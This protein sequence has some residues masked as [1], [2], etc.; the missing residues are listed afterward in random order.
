MSL[1]KYEQIILDV[2]MKTAALFLNVTIFLIK[3]ITFGTKINNGVD[4]SSCD[5]C[6]SEPVI[7][8]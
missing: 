4:T 6:V 7:D 3:K 5:T 2:K 1:Q 8:I